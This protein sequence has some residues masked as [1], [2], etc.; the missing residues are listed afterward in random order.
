MVLNLED[1]IP[2]LACKIDKKTE[3]HLSASE[4]PN[5]KV[6][7]SN[8]YDLFLQKMKNSS[9]T[10]TI[11][12]KLS[13]NFAEISSELS[14]MVPCISCRL[15]IERLFKQLI[16]RDSINYSLAL[17]PLRIDQFGLVTISPALLKPESLYTLFYVNG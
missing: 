16:P 8:F 4:I 2:C 5:S 17:D 1:L 7:K 9:E 15:S 11:I 6:Q 13:L 10:N 14:K 3:F 12:K